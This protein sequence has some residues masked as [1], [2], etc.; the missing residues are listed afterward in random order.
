MINPIESVDD[1]MISDFYSNTSSIPNLKSHNKGKTATLL[2]EVSARY[3]TIDRDRDIRI[4]R[5]SSIGAQ[6]ASRKS[7]R[8]RGEN[9]YD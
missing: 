8:V 3:R 4:S 1:S 9:P 2:P 5:K 7:S 6:E